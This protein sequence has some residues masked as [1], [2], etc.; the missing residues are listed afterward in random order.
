MTLQINAQE[1]HTISNVQDHTDGV[2]RRRKVPTP[3]SL[4]EELWMTAARDLLQPFAEM[5]LQLQTASVSSSLVLLSLVNAMLSN[6]CVLCLKKFFKWFAIFIETHQYEI[7]RSEYEYEDPS[8]EIENFRK[9]LIFVIQTR[10]GREMGNNETSAKLEH[11]K[12]K[13]PWNIK[14]FD[15][16]RSKQYTLAA[17]LDPRVKDLPF[18]GKLKLKRNQHLLVFLVIMSC[19]ISQL[20]TWKAAHLRERF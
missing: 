10:F 20:Q 16:F 11:P 1:P 9:D 18:E 15:I 6:T 2:A 4:K 3:L 12:T 8:E 14:T 5:V 17:L 19:E 7:N 13:K